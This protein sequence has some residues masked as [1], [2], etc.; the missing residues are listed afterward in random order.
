[1]LN[2]TMGNSS[3]LDPTRFH[4]TKLPQ[5]T[6]IDLQKGRRLTFRLTEPLSLAG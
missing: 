6:I 1:M 2:Q 3:A 4:S 5:A